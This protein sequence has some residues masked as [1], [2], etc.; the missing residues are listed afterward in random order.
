MTLYDKRKKSQNPII[1]TKYMVHLFLFNTNLCFISDLK[2]GKFS[3]IF[4]SPELIVSGE[5]LAMAKRFAREGR[6][7]LLWCDG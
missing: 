7:C 4:T 5:W 2:S 1:S 6:V 3:L